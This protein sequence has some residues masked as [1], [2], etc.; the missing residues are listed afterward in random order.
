MGSTSRRPPYARA[1]RRPRLPLSL[2]RPRPPRGGNQGP[3]AYYYCRPDFQLEHG[4]GYSMADAQTIEDPAARANRL[5]ELMN[6]HDGNVNDWSLKRLSGRT[7][8]ITQIPDHEWHCFTAG[9]Q[10]CTQAAVNGSAAV[11]R[12]RR[13]LHNQNRYTHTTAGSRLNAAAQAEGG[14]AVSSPESIY[15]KCSGLSGA[16]AGL[17]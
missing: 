11:A 8:G 14:E 15:S 6:I 12:R 10:R 13:Q 7:D 1:P 16:S 9:S 5:A 2:A 17:L 3:P 4:H